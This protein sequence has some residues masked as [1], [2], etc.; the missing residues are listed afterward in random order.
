MKTLLFIVIAA[1][2]VAAITGLIK[3]FKNREN[4]SSAPPP[5]I[6]QPA[7]TGLPEIDPAVEKKLSAYL[8][9]KT[10]KPYI[11]LTLVNGPADLYASKLGGIPYLPPNYPYPHN[12]KGEPLKLLAQLNFA[13]MP[14]L[15]GF[16]VT[17]ILQFYIHPNDDHYGAD[18]DHPTRQ[19]NFR[20]IYHETI[21]PNI[22]APAIPAAVR[23]NVDSFP[24]AGEKRL[25]ARLD[26]MPVTITDFRF[27][28]LFKPKLNELVQSAL[29]DTVYAYEYAY[30]E[31]FPSGGHR[32][33]GY[34]YFTQAD[35]REI[36]A[37]SHYT[38]L[39][40]QIDSDNSAGFDV[41]WGDVGVAN[42][43][44][45]PEALQ[46][47]DFSGVLYNWDCH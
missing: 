28:P 21:L 6:N 45:T 39:L 25:Q 17:G 19:D 33:G 26:S 47:K 7:G 3:D 32:L 44:I 36:K 14:R 20:V 27:E 12:A 43:F 40:L 1:V 9:E 46:R 11:N 2:I 10:S 23:G 24:F 42:F 8:T 13:Q 30:E 18:F 29:P 4:A 16:P 34:P 31:K 35:P 41:M 37:W 22:P 15:D 5:V 38:T